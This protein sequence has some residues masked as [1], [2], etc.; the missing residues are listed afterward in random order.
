M[1][2]V[3]KGI[4]RK[5]AECPGGQRLHIRPVLFKVF[6]GFC[7]SLLL[8]RAAPVESPYAFYRF[9]KRTDSKITCCS[10]CLLAHFYGPVDGIIDRPWLRYCVIAY[11]AVKSVFFFLKTTGKRGAAAVVIRHPKV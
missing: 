3:K 2:T 6:A 7:N 5:C 11:P 1:G 8:F 4:G 10:G 9:A